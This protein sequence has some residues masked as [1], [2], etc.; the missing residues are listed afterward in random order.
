MYRQPPGLLPVGNGEYVANPL[1]ENVKNLAAGYGQ[2]FQQLIRGEAAIQAYVMG[3]FRDLVT[4]KLVYPQFKRGLHTVNEAE[5]HK[6]WGKSGY[7]AMTFDFGRT[8]VCLLAVRK[9][10]GA[11]V[12]FDE[13]MANP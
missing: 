3:D 4:G 8:P 11:L 13:I 7:I 9:R 1:A 2:Y 6:I 10:N 12:I 5:F